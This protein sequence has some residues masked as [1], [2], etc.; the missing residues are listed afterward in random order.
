MGLSGKKEYE[1]EEPVRISSTSGLSGSATIL[2][3]RGT[4]SG[5][6]NQRE[7]QALTELHKPPYPCK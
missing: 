1:V 2:V 6:N 7:L 5:I 4:K 3:G